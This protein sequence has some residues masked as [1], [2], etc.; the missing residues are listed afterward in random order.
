VTSTAAILTV[1]DELMLGDRIDTNGPWLSIELKAHGIETIERRSVHDRVQAIAI[2]M[3]SLAMNCDLLLVTGGLGPTEDD[4]TRK[5]FAEAIGSRLE[6]NAQAHASMA[7]WFAKRDALMP[8][9]NDVQAM[10]PTGSSWIPNLH[11]TA[12]GLQG[13][14]GDCMV[15]CLPGPPNELQPMFQSIRDDVFSSLELGTSLQTSEIHSWGMPESIAGEKIDDLM[16]SED[17]S[18]SILMGAEG[19]TARVTGSGGQDMNATVQEITRR[20]SPWV[21]GNDGVSLAESVGSLLVERDITL[22]TAESC[23]GGALSGLLVGVP[24]ASNWF[25]GG[26]VTYSNELKIS[27]L[28]IEQKMIDE[29]GAVS[30]E[31]AVAMCHSAIER[32][33][34]ACALSTTG[35]SGPTGGSKEKPVGSVYIG[36]SV[37]G[38]MHVRLFRFSGDRNT[39]TIRAACTALQLL[40]LQL[41][42]V[43]AQEMC[44]QHGLA[45]RC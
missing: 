40:R 17:P 29:H 24:G 41:S 18:V 16:Q 11:G 12:P 32:S 13:K 20:W 26:W 35:I 44:W 23:T 8:P 7:E 4:R 27:Q 36:C 5:A 3:T 45:I 15:L 2:A 31:V 38:E 33:G 34:A 6:M 28:G 37:D 25:Q 22:A 1:G 30:A 39:I 42:G 9:T 19:I 14:I 21:Y 10:V 43:D